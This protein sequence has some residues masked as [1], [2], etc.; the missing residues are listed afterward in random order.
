MEE[1]RYL[2]DFYNNY[3]EDSR[4]ASRH[5]SVEL[6]EHNIELFRQ[7]TESGEKVSVIRGN[8]MDLS[9]FS[10]N[11]FDITLLLG[12]LYHLYNKADKRKALSEAIR[13]TKNGG[14]CHIRRVSP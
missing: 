8:A 1:N 12:P 3:D 2:L 7:N 14:I 11:S 10:D 4:L 13:V 9:V 6:V 5:G